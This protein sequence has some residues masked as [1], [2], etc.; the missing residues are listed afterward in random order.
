MLKKKILIA[1]SKMPLHFA[2]K[3]C[4]VAQNQNMAKAARDLGLSQ[5]TIS[6]QIMCIEEAFGEKLFIRNGS[7]VH[8]TKEGKI[9]FHAFTKGLEAIMHINK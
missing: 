3:F 6:R 8:L 9:V 4:L 5:S 1:L 7:G 2:P